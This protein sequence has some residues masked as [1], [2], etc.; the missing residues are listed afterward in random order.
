MLC[1]YT[2]SGFA[3][4]LF[5]L[6]C[7]VGSTISCQFNGRSAPGTPDGD[8][9]GDGDA[10]PMFSEAGRNGSGR[11]VVVVDDDEGGRTSDCFVAVANITPSSFCA[12]VR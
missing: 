5:S 1:S 3:T 7:V 6:R 9:D 2:P 4:F 11:R 12:V 10:E 8:V